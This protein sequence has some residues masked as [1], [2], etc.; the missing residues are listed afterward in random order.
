MI[1]GVGACTGAGAGAPAAGALVLAAPGAAFVPVGGTPLPACL[2]SGLAVF[3]NGACFASAL[4]ALP[5]GACLTSALVA[6]ACFAPLVAGVDCLASAFVDGA[7]VPAGALAAGAWTA[8]FAESF[9]A[10]ALAPCA[11]AGAAA[12]PSAS[13]SARARFIVPSLR[14]WRHTSGSRIAG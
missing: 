2:V 7:L 1:V 8:P 13:A 6:G 14:P 3:P 11:A 9:L 4:A 5:T 10:G 12:Q